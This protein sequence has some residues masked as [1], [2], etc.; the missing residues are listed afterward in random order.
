MRRTCK[1][2]AALSVV[3]GACMINEQVTHLNVF[4]LL[5]GS[6]LY[7]QI[8]E[9]TPFAGSLRGIYRRGCIWRDVNTSIHMVMV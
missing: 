5:G 7:P 1:T 4:G 9:E 3:L 8:R 2:F 6:P